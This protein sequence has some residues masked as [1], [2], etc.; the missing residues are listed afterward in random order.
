[1]LQARKQALENSARQR[2]VEIRNQELNYYTDNCRSIGNSAALVA[3]LAYSGIR[4]HYLLERKQNYRS[5]TGTPSA[6]FFLSLLS[7]TLG[8]ALQTV[9]VAMLVALF[10]PHLALRG[11]DGAL[12][13]A[14]EGMHVWNSVVLAL[15]FTSLLLLQLSAFPSC[16]ATLSSTVATGCWHARGAGWLACVL[17]LRPPHHPPASSAQGTSRDRRLLRHRGRGLHRRRVP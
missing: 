13:D 10:G 8:T 17:A 9:Y 7:I 15:F 12:H 2:M 1:M 14:V 4:Y 5:T 16:T 3:G 6:M 11:P